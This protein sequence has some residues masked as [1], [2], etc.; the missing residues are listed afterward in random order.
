MIGLLHRIGGFFLEG[1][2]LDGVAIIEVPI[3]FRGDKRQVRLLEAD[4]QEERLALFLQFF[5]QTDAVVRNRAVGIG[6]VRHVGGL[7]C[8]PAVVLHQ[9]R[10]YLLVFREPLRLGFLIQLPGRFTMI[11][12]QHGFSRR[13][14]FNMDR[15]GERDR[16]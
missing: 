10:F 15:I 8:R 2:N 12:P 16:P 11:G 3:F 7:D 14:I 6:A 9:I 5:H 13:L 4:R 1:G